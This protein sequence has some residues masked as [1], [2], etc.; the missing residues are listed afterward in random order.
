[1]HYYLASGRSKHVEIIKDWWVSV[2]TV[3]LPPCWSS[4]FAMD[5]CKKLPFLPAVGRWRL[6]HVV[7]KWLLGQQY[8]Y[9][10]G[11]LLYRVQEFVV[12][13]VNRSL[14]ISQVGSRFPGVVSGTVSFLLD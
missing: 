11:D 10:G 9:G 6:H 4:A 2:L 8:K 5:L 1:M 12:E 14:S 13:F 3:I 7:D